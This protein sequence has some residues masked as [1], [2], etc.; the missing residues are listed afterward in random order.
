MIYN[1]NVR[2]QLKRTKTAS[3]ASGTASENAV[4]LTDNRVL[5]VAQLHTIAINSPE[6][7]QFVLQDRRNAGLAA[8]LTMEY[9]HYETAGD[10]E[11]ARDPRE[12]IIYYQAAIERRIEVYNLH[13][14]EAA[15]DAAHLRAIQFIER[16]IDRLS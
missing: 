3:S 1:R 10:H 13:V 2:I 16:K 14:P 12:A 7:L 8:R 5:P 9:H 15:A 4:Q 11:A 6:P